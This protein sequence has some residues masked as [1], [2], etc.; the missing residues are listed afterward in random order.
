MLSDLMK[1][2]FDDVPEAAVAAARAYE[3]LLVPALLAE[4]A[5]KVVQAAGLTSGD[6]V[7]DVGCGTGAL[8]RAAAAAVASEAS[9]TGV[10]FSRGMLAVASELSPGITWLEGPAEDLPVRD[11][12]VDAVVSQFALMFFADRERALR[13][14]QRV[15]APGGR[16]AVTVW[17]GVNEIP[18]YAAEVALFR[19]TIGER[20][21]TAM[22]APF[23]LGDR[24]VLA[25]L[26]TAAGL[27]A[28]IDTLS[29]TGRFA[30]ARAMVEPDLVG[31]LPMMGVTLTDDDVARVLDEAVGVLQ[32]FTTGAGTL[33]FE[34]RA[35]VITAR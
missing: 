23:A 35:H 11:A 20:G 14:M 4:W 30:S 3:H 22:E 26:F 28:S 8:A 34:T 21:A 13:E 5:P 2:T 33:E 17:C 25:D 32:P 24:A 6:R 7:L 16:I 19:R 15:L 18:A 29:G 1:Q 10:D 31:W 9:V 12:S 27:D